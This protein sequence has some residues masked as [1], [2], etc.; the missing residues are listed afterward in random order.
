MNARFA[1]FAACLVAL[2]LRAGAQDAG[3]AGQ[4]QTLA[5]PQLEQLVAPVALY[6]DPLLTDVL[7]AS[8]YPAQVVEAERFASDPAS[9]SL[10]G[11]AL[12]DAAA[13]HDWDPSVKALLAFPQVLQ[14]MDRQL[15][16][17][18]HLGQ[19]FIAQQADVLNAV[20]LLRQQAELAGTLQNGPNESVVDEGGNILVSPPSPQEIYLP[21]V[22]AGCA[23]D[24]AAGCSGSAVQWSDG[25]ILPFG[26]VQWGLLDWRRRQIHLA[27]RDGDERFKG[28]QAATRVAA[29]EFWRPPPRMR[30]VGRAL[31]A[32]GFNDAPPASVP[33]A[34]RGF[35]GARLAPRA[36][37]PMRAAL[38]AFRAPLARAPAPIAAPHPAVAHVGG[39]LAR[40]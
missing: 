14:M 3:Y 4:Q 27:H 8:T 29:G 39:G 34:A 31:Q 36:A 21:S 15:E 19:A 5:E 9:A 33:F 38:P 40:H 35:A 20:Q 17:T 16:W 11:A 22:D 37:L 24:L 2:S 7:A 12:I 13:G 6:P 1:A 32:G 28:G 25:I 23:Y 30:A 10:P 26:Y 18:E